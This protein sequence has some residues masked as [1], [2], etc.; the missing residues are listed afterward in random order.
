MVT[1]REQCLGGNAA[2]LKQDSPTIEEK[3]ISFGL[4]KLY[5]TTIYS[6]QQI[7]KD[8]IWMNAYTTG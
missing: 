5:N 2:L 8:N 7:R 4:F 1:K 6:G 3:P